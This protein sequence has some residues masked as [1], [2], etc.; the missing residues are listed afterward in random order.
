MF[1][2]LSALAFGGNGVYCLILLSTILPEFTFDY[3]G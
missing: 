2:E 1:S 3:K